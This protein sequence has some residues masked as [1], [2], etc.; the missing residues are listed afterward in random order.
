MQRNYSNLIKEYL[1]IDAQR[2]KRPPELSNQFFCHPRQQ[3]QTMAASDISRLTSQAG[4]SAECQ[5]QLTADCRDAPCR[6]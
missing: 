2:L 1:C 4:G 5:R 6:Y 3:Y